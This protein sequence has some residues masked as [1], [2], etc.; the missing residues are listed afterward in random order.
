LVLF[1][2]SLL[3]PEY[4]VLGNVMLPGFKLGKYSKE[5]LEHERWAFKTLEIENT[6]Q[7][8]ANQLS[9]GEK[10]RVAIARAQ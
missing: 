2:N 10:Q 1:F 4:N 3:L 6:H 7:K 5:E 9:G 8:N